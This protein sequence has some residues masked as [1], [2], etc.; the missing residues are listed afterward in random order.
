MSWVKEKDRVWP[1][2]V[3]A[4]RLCLG[5]WRQEG[6]EEF[7]GGY[8]FP[9]AGTHREVDGVE[10]GF[11]AEA[12]AEVGAAVDVG[13]RFTTTRAD[14]DELAVAA[15]VGPAQMADQPVDGDVV[16]QPPEELVVVSFAGHGHL[17]R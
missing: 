14:E 13:A 1:V 16:A 15:F 3:G 9:L 10:V 17:L 12:A 5:A 4:W 6:C 7:D 2:L 11:A 8:E